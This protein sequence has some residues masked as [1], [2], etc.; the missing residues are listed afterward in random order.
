MSASVC[1]AAGSELSVSVA[2]AALSQSDAGIPRPA[3]LDVPK[4]AVIVEVVGHDDLPQELQALVA[5]LFFDAQ[6]DRRAM[7]DRQL[8][9][10]HSIS[11]DGLRM[12]RID[13][14]DAVGPVIVRVEL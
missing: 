2:S 13:H 9:A 14:V 3:V 6:P 12:Q 4:R 8:A 1:A 10:V 5:E 7:A 11:Q